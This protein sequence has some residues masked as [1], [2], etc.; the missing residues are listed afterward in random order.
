ME[1]EKLSELRSEATC[2]VCSYPV[3]PGNRNASLQHAE[4]SW[5]YGEKKKAT[6]QHQQ[7]H[8]SPVSPWPFFYKSI[9]NLALSQL[10]LHHFP[11]PGRPLAPK[12]SL[13]IPIHTNP[14]KRAQEQ[15]Q[16]PLPLYHSQQTAA[17]SHSLM[18][19]LK[20]RLWTGPMRPFGWISCWSN[21]WRRK[22]N[23][24]SP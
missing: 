17:I 3:F 9:S 11:Q 21:I 16:C 22:I 15:L 6:S 2:W 23:L 5:I 7:L 19:D 13:L 10:S 12:A 14:V 4:N 24:R 8:P 1:Q 18:V 20:V